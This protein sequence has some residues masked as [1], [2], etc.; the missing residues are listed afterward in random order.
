MKKNFTFSYQ[1]VFSLEDVSDSDKEL[2]DRATDAMKSS[3]SS[4]SNFSVGAA[5]ILENNQ[6]V[7]GSN[8]ENASFPCGICAE[9]VALF[10]SSAN[11]PNLRI[12]TIAIT[13][14][15]E[16]FD[17]QEPVGPCGA[18]RQVLLE[19]EEKQNSNIEILLFDMKKIIKI[20]RAKDLLPLYFQENKLKK[21]SN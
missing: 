16:N 18:C 9:R 2:M 12:K 21:Q 5:L 14:K 3:Y 8:Q 10:S 17:I 7:I 20:E 1:E 19:Y 11:F 6:I 13:A 4:Y 15:S